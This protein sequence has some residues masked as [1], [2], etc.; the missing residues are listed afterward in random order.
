MSKIK[1]E[2]LMDV[3]L[4]EYDKL[5]QE[6]TQRIG[7]RDNLIY[8]N[9]IAITGIT[10]VAISSI[11][12]FPVLLITPLASIT[13]GWIYLNNDYKISL[14]GWYIKNELNE[15]ISQ[16]IA[17]KEDLIFKW[18]DASAGDPK[19]KTRKI[20]QLVI[21]ECI[22]VLPGFLAVIIYWYYGEKTLR[23]FSLFWIPF[24]VVLFFQ[25]INYAELKK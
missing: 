24:L 13:L 20:I 14:I 8:A 2:Y 16:A 10:S 6:Q 5:K 3:Y 21:D 22:F 25:I 11:E 4:A 9:L 18:E 12:A 1:K 23:Y 7:F 19:R 15:K 17:V